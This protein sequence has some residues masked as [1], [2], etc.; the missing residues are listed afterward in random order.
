MCGK[1]H[2]VLIN[3]IEI[4]IQSYFD[5]V[6]VCPLWKYLSVYLYICNPFE[7]SQFVEMFFTFILIHKIACLNLY[8]I[9]HHHFYNKN[10]VK[11]DWN[12]IADRISLAF[13]TQQNIPSQE[14][15][16]NLL[17]IVIIVINLFVISTNQMQQPNRL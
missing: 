13:R 12:T 8:R 16:I 11:T 4:D 3:L 15:R 10:G 17:I 5:A 9:S 7:I 2:G 6:I 1:N 14:W